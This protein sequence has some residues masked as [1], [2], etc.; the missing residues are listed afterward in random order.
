VATYIELARLSAIKLASLVQSTGKFVYSYDPHSKERHG[1]Y[2]L[3]RHA[4]SVWAM[5]STVPETAE[6]GARAM[7]WLEAK[8]YAVMEQGV[9]IVSKDHIKLGGNGLA[10]LAHLALAT[11]YDV[12]LARRLADFILSRQQSDGDYDHKVHVNGTVHPF[13]SAYYTGEMMFSLVRLYG[14]TRDERYL[15]SVISTEAKLAPHYG[16]KEQSH[17]M[18]HALNELDKHTASNAHEEHALNI[19]GNIIEKPL[20]LERGRSCPTACRTEG[21]MAAHEM[22]LRR[23]HDRDASILRQIRQRC[24][25]NIEQQLKFRTEDGGF[26]EGYD[27]ARVQIDY[28]QHALTGLYAYGKATQT[29]AVAVEE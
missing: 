26:S 1:G 21:L 2:N 27:S 24:E 6:A 23:G 22:L 16:V 14:V 8:H 5:V 9:A 7:R 12:N 11:E 4:G 29:E 10:I 18:L 15:Q 19:V 20:Y 13:R 25:V 17:W 28:I 3:L